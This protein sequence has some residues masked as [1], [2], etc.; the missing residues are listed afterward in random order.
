[1]CGAEEFWYK[2]GCGYARCGGGGGGGL[3]D[4]GGGGGGGGGGLTWNVHP[5]HVQVHIPSTIFIPAYSMRQTN[6]SSEWVFYEWRYGV[7]TYYE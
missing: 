2:A 3:G 6:L 5:T 4:E 7:S 1:M